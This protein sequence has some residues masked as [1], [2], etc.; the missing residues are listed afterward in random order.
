MTRKV[1]RARILKVLEREGYNYEPNYVPVLN[2][3]TNRRVAA[4]LRELLETQ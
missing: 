2:G 4:L 1:L 3:A